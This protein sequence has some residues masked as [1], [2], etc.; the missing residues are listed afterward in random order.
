MARDR[1][2]KVELGASRLYLVGAAHSIAREA[3]VRRAA[4]FIGLF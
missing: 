3:T 4:Q 1:R 2:A